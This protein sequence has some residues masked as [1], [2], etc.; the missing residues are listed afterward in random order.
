MTQNS[1]YLIGIHAGHDANVTVMNSNGEILF[2]AGEE[3]F[4]RKKMFAGF[5]KGA[6]E[7]AISRFGKKYLYLSTPRMSASRK[8]VR[9][10]GFLA[11]SLRN[12]LAA[13]R[14]SIWMKDRM[15]RLGKGRL[16]EQ[17]V[18][19]DT[20]QSEQG[21]RNVE[22]HHA[23]AAS[24]FY[25]SGFDRAWVMTLDGEGDGYSCCIYDADRDS[26]LH[27][28]YAW[29]HNDI[30]T[31]RDY[32]K[33]TAMLGFH[34]VRH[35]GK[36]TG[37]AAHGI[38]NENCIERLRSY[39]SRSWKSDR[40]SMF[41]PSQAYQIISEEGRSELRKDRE[42]KFGEFSREDISYA[43]QYLTEE[44]V[45]GL[46]NKYIPHPTGKNI[47]V[48]GGVFANVTLNK[49]LKNLGFE[50]IFVQPAMTDCGLSYGAV[51]FDAPFR[52]QLKRQKDVFLGPSYTP[53]EIRDILRKENISFQNPSDMASAVAV[54]LADGKVVARFDGKM[55]F[56]PRALGNRSILYH[57]GDPSVNDWLNKQLKRSEFMPFAP[58]T[59]ERFAADRFIGYRGAEH[60]SKFMTITF[61]CTDRM[62]K[63]SPAVVHVDGTARPQVLAA[64]DNPGYA[65]ILEEYL[66]LTGVPTLVNTSFNMHEEPIVMTPSDALRAYFASGLDAMILGPFLLRASS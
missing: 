33:V 13:P 28:R 63:E 52:W 27:R 1:R 8:I 41:S 6:L 29:Y 21:V 40:R 54:L 20:L 3:R 46:V 59:L 39:L 17:G 24:A 7:Y 55:E 35:P 61:D 5:P 65:A 64:D 18:A 38:Y 9:E 47:C 62:K 23:H 15:S 16:L 14:F 34:P 57:T 66:K 25:P 56:G 31:G 32:E 37:L 45:L 50:N 30:T 4:N 11:H 2:A 49:K 36:I 26:G 22:H 43:I 51:L 60:T 10:L 12:G 48:A 58:V 19:M 53:D 44:T 42:T